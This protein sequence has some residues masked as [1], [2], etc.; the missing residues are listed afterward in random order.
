MGYGTLFKTVICIIDIIFIIYINL[1]AIKIGHQIFIWK[2]ILN[3]NLH[4]HCYGMK[5]VKLD[6]IIINRYLRYIVS[7]DLCSFFNFILQNNLNIIIIK[8]INT[9]IFILNNITVLLFFNW[10][11]HLIL[12]KRTTFYN[13]SSIC[14]LSIL[15]WTLSS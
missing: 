11:L 12:I 9:H 15:V 1:K 14:T 8:S 2:T 10:I 6:I 13:L 3:I 4:F 5:W 7:T